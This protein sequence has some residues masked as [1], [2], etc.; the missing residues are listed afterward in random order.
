MTVLTFSGP[1]Q[2][3]T[4]LLPVGTYYF[5]I[6]DGD[7]GFITVTGKN[8]RFVTRFSVSATTRAKGGEKV[9]MRAVEGKPS[10]VSALYPTGGTSGMEFIYH[11]AKK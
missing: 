7:D 5:T 11:R 8:S 4:V 3:P 10:E 6:H 9:V 1:V 2:L